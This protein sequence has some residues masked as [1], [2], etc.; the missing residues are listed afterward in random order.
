MADPATALARAV[1]PSTAS[2]PSSP[3]LA[4]VMFLISKFAEGAWVVVVAVPTFILLF[5]RINAYYQTGW[6]SELGVG[7]VPGQA[8]RASRPW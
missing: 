1:R 2:A 6:H 8:R 4:T 3:A 5:K 7:T